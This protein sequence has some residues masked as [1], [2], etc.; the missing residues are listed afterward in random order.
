MDLTALYYRRQAH[1]DV[2]NE[3]H[4]SDTPFGDVPQSLI[5]NAL[6]QQF[7]ARNSSLTPIAE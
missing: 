4:A 2:C 7:E 3:F 6:I 1:S 5:S